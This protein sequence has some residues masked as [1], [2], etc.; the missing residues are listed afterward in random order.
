MTRHRPHIVTRDPA[1]VRVALVYK[2]TQTNRDVSHVGLGV[3][4]LLTQRTL[5]AA[6]YHAETWAVDSPAEL[7]GR[8][9][10]AQDAAARTGGHPVSHVVIA[11][12]WI[13]T[14]ELQRLLAAHPDV[15]WVVECHSNFGFL[16]ADPAGARLMREASA[17]DAG[18]HNFRAAGN[19]R[20][21]CDAWSVG[22]GSRMLLLPNLYDVSTIH[23]VGQRMPWHP[24]HTL[25]VGVFGAVRPLKNHT[26][27][28]AAAIQLAAELHNDVE[29]HVSAGRVEGGGV[30]LDAVAQLTANVPGVRL[31]PSGWRSWPEFR[32][33]LGTMHVLLQPSFTESFNVVTADGIASGVASAVSDAID[34]VP[35]DWMA[36]ADDAGDVAR[37]ARR[38]LHD[39]HAVS[40]GQAA[41]RRYVADGLACW[42]RYLTGAA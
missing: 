19:C 42:E 6:G 16:M 15:Q 38:L 32:R 8:L 4:A 30:A 29:I 3:T 34:W 14:P 22:Y 24:G 27:A 28:V 35:R 40:A 7:A 20:K 41:L 31:V 1:Q 26:T 11:A 18:S 37:V 10:A 5:L 23:H 33:L 2:N 13:A 36:G 21:F 25:R 17:L 9:A 12:P 39:A